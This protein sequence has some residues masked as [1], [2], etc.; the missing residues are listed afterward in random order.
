MMAQ[1][2][3]SLLLSAILIYA[4]AER[5]RSPVVGAL[6]L[7]AAV[8]GLYFVWVPAHATALAELAGIGRGVDL[9]IYTWVV[10]SLLVLLNL[11]LKLRSQTEVIT[12]LARAFAIDEALRA[13]PQDAPE[14]DAEPVFRR[15]SSQ[16][17]TRTSPHKVRMAPRTKRAESGSSKAAAAA[18]G[19]IA[20]EIATNK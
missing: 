3:L 20:N 18:I 8:A 12:G 10:I 1:L 13:G 19:T 2:L 7:A 4:F 17:A 5:R 9:I 16:A 15:R 11:H 6:A 14:G